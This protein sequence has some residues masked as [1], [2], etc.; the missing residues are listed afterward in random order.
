MSNV[1]I[2]LGAVCLALL[3]GYSHDK[4]MRG[5]AAAGAVMAFVCVMGAWFNFLKEN[6]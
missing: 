6:S 2:L 4:G 5:L 3:A 1:K